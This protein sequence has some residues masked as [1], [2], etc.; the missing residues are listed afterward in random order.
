[1]FYFPLSYR[2]LLA[3]CVLVEEREE[4][5]KEWEMKEIDRRKSCKEGEK[6]KKRGDDVYGKEEEEKEV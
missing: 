1:M 6:I 2:R 3:S 4:G 5:G